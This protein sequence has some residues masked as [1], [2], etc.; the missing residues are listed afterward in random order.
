MSFSS[1]A[2][3]GAISPINSYLFFEVLTISNGFGAPSVSS[4]FFSSVVDSPS[5]FATSDPSGFATSE[6]SGFATSESSGFLSYS[7]LVTP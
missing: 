4:V 1:F 3:F 5:S 6:S 7:S 2:L